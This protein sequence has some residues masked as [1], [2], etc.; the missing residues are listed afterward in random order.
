[1]YCF[2]MSFFLLVLLLPQTIN[3]LR[4]GIYGLFIS[5]SP[6]WTHHLVDRM[7]LAYIEEWIS[8]K[9]INFQKR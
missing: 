2:Q 4:A 1:M 6:G 9:M 7:Y 3:S 5:R 8:K